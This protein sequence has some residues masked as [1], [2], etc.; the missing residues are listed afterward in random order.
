MLY[1][2]VAALKEY[3]FLNKS[4]KNFISLFFSRENIEKLLLKNKNWKNP[5]DDLCSDPNLKPLC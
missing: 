1:A 5:V 3:T 4:L 2:A